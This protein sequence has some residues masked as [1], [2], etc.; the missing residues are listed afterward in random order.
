MQTR[1]DL[2]C[3]SDTP[4]SGVTAV[5]AFLTTL[6]GAPHE[7]MIDFHIHSCRQLHLPVAVEP[8]RTDGLWQTTCVELFLKPEGDSGYIEYN[9]SPSFAW[10]AYA[11]DDYRTGMREL[12]LTF[13][14]DIQLSPY[15]GLLMSVHA[16]LDVSACANRET[17]VG[18]SAVIE[19]ADGTKSYWALAHAP[20]PPDFHNPACFTAKLPAPPAP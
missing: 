11:F 13:E 10:A 17:A 15:N 16:E 18:L 12:P 7:R 14:P 2:T 3:H 1:L 4:S 19:E 20:G 5:Y 9:L 6:G 8:V